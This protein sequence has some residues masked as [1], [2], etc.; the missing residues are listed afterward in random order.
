MNNKLINQNSEKNE[1]LWW[2]NIWVDWAVLEVDIDEPQY[3]KWNNERRLIYKKKN[4]S[5]DVAYNS[6]L[7][8]D[9][10]A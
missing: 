1:V 10:T 2:W 4:E 3:T 5:V 7:N 9:E 6:Q 8:C